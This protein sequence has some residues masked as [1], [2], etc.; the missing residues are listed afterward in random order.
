L[1]LSRGDGVADG[2][3]VSM[4]FL[5]FSHQALYFMGLL[6][7]NE[8]MQSGFRHVISEWYILF[9]NHC[10]ISFLVEVGAGILFI[11]RCVMSH[12]IFQHFQQQNLLQISPSTI[13]R[14]F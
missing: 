14:M 4:T 11:L 5:Y 13:S 3:A 6:L 7:Q 10:C 1:G 9:R 8:P 2:S 12:Y